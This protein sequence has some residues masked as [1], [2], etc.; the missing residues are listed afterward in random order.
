[1]A[2][3][4]YSG[5]T[6]TFDL[7]ER[8]MYGSDRLGMD[9]ASVSLYGLTDLYY[10]THAPTSSSDDDVRYELK[11]HLGNVAVIVTAAF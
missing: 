8:P 3:Y 1:M 10:G 9:I 7:I 2:T 4:Q 11:D 6:P 5:G